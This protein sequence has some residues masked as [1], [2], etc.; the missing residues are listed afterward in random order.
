MACGARVLGLRCYAIAVSA[1]IVGLLTAGAPDAWGARGVAET[2]GQAGVGAGQFTFAS[3]VGLNQTSGDVYVA[4]APIN[5]SGV[6]GQRVEQFSADG[7]FVR[8]WGWGVATGSDAF[9]VCSI[10][11]QAGLTGAGD[12]QFAFQVQADGVF[13]HPQVAV[14]QSDGSVYVADNLNDRVQKF[15]ATGAFSSSS[16]PAGAET[17][18]EH[19][20]GGDGRLRV[21][22]RIRR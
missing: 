19:A 17:A 4:D 20:A 15:S 22:R 11:C 1:L 13:T 7:S 3:G 14:D 18:D 9:E 2:F 6:G 16:A 5:A 21:G 10:A 8:T 12:G